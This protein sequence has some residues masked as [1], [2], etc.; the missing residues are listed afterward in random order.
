MGSYVLW[1]SGAEESMRVDLC[2]LMSPMPLVKGWAKPQETPKS[3]M[4]AFSKYL[5]VLKSIPKPFSVLGGHRM[6]KYMTPTMSSIGKFE[7]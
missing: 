1:P 3:K 5:K 6:A 2:T 4:A 7:L